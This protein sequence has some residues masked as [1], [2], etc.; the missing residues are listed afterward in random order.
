MAIDRRSLQYRTHRS[1]PSRPQIWRSTLLSHNSHP[2]NGA[3]LAISGNYGYLA[4]LL[5]VPGPAFVY[6]P[7]AWI[8]FTDP[9]LGL[10]LQASTGR[11]SHRQPP[12]RAIHQTRPT[13]VHRRPVPLLSDYPSSFLHCNSLTDIDGSFPFINT[14]PL[15]RSLGSC[16]LHTCVRHIPLRNKQ[17]EALTVTFSAGVAPI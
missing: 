14:A 15:R 2:A 3:F 6:K 9:N 7:N 1:P 4:S 17:P 11:A 8:S 10:S 13:P 12:V 16:S 5:P